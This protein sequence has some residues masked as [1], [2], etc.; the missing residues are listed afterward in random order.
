MTNSG[1][2]LSTWLFPAAEGPSYSRG[3][4]VNLGCAITTRKLL[5]LNLTA[6]SLM[7]LTLQLYLVY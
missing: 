6:W 5:F 4:L 7:F 1:G 2:I 3:T